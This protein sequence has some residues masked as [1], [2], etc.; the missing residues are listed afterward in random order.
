MGIYL[1]ILVK[2][3]C[4][5]NEGPILYINMHSAFAVSYSFYSV[6]VDIWFCECTILV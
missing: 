4:D 3:G 2:L 1:L 5:E 6:R